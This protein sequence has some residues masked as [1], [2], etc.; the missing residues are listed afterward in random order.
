[1]AAAASHPIPPQDCFYRGMMGSE[2]NMGVYRPAQ[3]DTGV[4]RGY[5]PDAWSD[6]EAGH[7][8]AE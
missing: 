5:V 8:S 2:A 6:L 1:M 4:Y 3:T 7:H